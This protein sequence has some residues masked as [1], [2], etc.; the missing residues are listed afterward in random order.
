MVIPDHRLTT[1]YNCPVALTQRDTQRQQVTTLLDIMA[2]RSLTHF[3]Q[4]L[5]IVHEAEQQSVVDQRETGGETCVFDN[6]TSLV[7]ESWAT[8][9]VELVMPS[10]S[11]YPYIDTFNTS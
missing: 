9:W 6:D 4:F 11:L 5:D 7:P 3:K 1:G 10:H 8:K 2:R